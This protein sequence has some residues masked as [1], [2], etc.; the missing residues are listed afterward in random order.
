V[1]P[2]SD[3]QALLHYIPM[4]QTPFIMHTSSLCPEGEEILKDLWGG[5]SW[6]QP[7]FRRPEPA[8]SRLRAILPAP[9]CTSSWLKA[10][11]L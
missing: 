2:E 4:G 6:P 5:Q 11:A 9:R 10:G 8:E 3:K 7:P 1:Q